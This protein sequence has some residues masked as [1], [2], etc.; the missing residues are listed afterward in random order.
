MIG[1]SRFTVASLH[2]SPV[3]LSRYLF[4]KSVES[5]TARTLPNDGLR[6]FST[7]S[8]QMDRVDSS[9]SL[10][11]TSSNNSP[12]RSLSGVP[13][14]ISPRCFFASNLSRSLRATDFLVDLLDSEMG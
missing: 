8:F 3:R 11:R 7:T 10:L 14:V 9:I 6:F 5:P 1:N 13:P 12:I 2:P 4:I